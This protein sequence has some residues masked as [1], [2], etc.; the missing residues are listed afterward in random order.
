M[1]KVE[2]PKV[3]LPARGGLLPAANVIRDEADIAAYHGVSYEGLP[4][5]ISREIPAAG[6]DKAFDKYVQQQGVLFGVYRGLETPTLMGKPDT[7][8]AKELFGAGETVAVEKAVQRLLLNPKAVDITPT[9]G[10]AVKNYKQ[11]LGLLQ[12][13]AAERYTGLPLLHANRFVTELLPEMVADPETWIQ[14]TRQGV[15]LANGG[16]YGTAGPGAR[17]AAAGAG[18]LYISGQINIWQG[19]LNLIETTNQYENRNYVLAE[20]TYAA[21]VEGFVAAI[22]VGI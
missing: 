22:L 14:H 4:A 10:T 7:A 16:G 17:T 19:E 12:Q 11:A 2:A 13:Y 6:T 18:W 21:S 20:A 1:F 8:D 3:L 9:P 5:G 15:P